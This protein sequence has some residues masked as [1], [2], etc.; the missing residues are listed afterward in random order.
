[1]M[2]FLV[3]LTTPEEFLRRGRCSHPSRYRQKPS[4]SSLHQNLRLT[5]R[6]SDMLP[7]R[8]EFYFARKYLKS[9]VLC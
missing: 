1:M 6:H 3:E 9:W 2:I 5:G 8:V 7:H 4:L